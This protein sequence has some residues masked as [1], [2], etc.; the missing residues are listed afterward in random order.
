MREEIQD[1]LDMIRKALDLIE[2]RSFSLMQNLDAHGETVP[3]EF[4]H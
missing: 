1:D 4:I 3:M 2:N